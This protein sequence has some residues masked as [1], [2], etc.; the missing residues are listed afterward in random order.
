METRRTLAKR[1]LANGQDRAFKTQAAKRTS[2]G[3]LTGFAA[4]KKRK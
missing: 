1:F 2:G 3:R 4:A